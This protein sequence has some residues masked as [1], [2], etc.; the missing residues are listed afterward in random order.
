MSNE[1]LG[2]RRVIRALRAAAE[3]L[4]AS[5]FN[6]ADVE[7]AMAL[8]NEHVPAK[9]GFI[10]LRGRAP[11]LETEMGDITL[12]PGDVDD[13]LMRFREGKARGLVDLVKK[14]VYEAT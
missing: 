1:H 9:V 13:I 6:S 8:V 12:T 11:V 14:I 5:A 10:T 3:R 7:K 2:Y 4:E